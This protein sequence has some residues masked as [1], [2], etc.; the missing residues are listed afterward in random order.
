MSKLLIITN[1]WAAKMTGGAYHILKVARY[2]SNTDTVNY[3]IP[4]LGY[5]SAKAYLAGNVMIIN[6]PFERETTTAVG[7]AL[8]FCARIVRTLFSPPRE[9]YDAVVASSHFLV[10]VLPAAYLRS[11]NPTCKLIV[12][13]HG[14]PIRKA[15][16]AWSL[17]RSLNDTIAVM[18]LRKHANRIFAINQPVK[19][20]LVEKGV[21]KERIRLI[22]NGTDVIT[23]SVNSDTRGL[24]ACFVGRL[25]KN[26]GIFDLIK[27][28]K[29]VVM[30]K[31]TARLAIVGDGPDRES[32]IKEIKKESL[33]GNITLCGFVSE[34]SK[35]AILQNSKLLLLPSYGEGLPIVFI[36]AMGCGV[37]I[38][39]YDFPEL[40]TTL[41][42]AIFYASPGDIDTFS[43]TVA[44]LLSN[45]ELHTTSAQNGLELSKQ[46]LW[47]NIA[48]YE[49][50]SIVEAQ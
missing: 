20:F 13:Y 27:I 37:P 2:W 1:E 4:Q 22:T 17:L 26:K 25:V 8:L 35:F 50:R 49:L 43:S 28:W 18:V 40:R 9:Q 6:S 48:Q 39:A 10:D 41:G 24:D 34:D 38:I 14:L 30:G 47:S 44:L 45:K 36:E 12:Y 11:K 31:P 19:D 32:L 23:R 16:R 33:E 42:D 21:N 7:T 46:Y 29:L 3:L 15:T 5:P